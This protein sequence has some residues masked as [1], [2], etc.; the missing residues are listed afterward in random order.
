M[1]KSIQAIRGMNDLLPD[2][3]A[4]WQ[5]V[6]QTARDTLHAYGYREIRF[7][8]VEKTDLFCRAVGQATDIVE[9]E[10][11]TFDDRNGDSL[12]LRPEGTACAVRTG[13]E[14][15]LLHNQVQRLWYI[16]PMFRHERP[17]KGRY[18]QFHQIGVE[19]FGMSGPDIDAE[20][21]MLS[22]R[23][24]RA[25]GLEG[26]TLELNS[27]GTPDARKQYR[28]ELVKYL[29]KHRDSLDNDSLRRLEKNPLRVLDSKDPG[30]QKIVANAPE[31]ADYLDEESKT[32]FARLKRYL[33][34]AG[35]AYVVNPRLVRGLDYYSRTVFEWTTDQLGAQSAVCAGGRFD[36]LVE[37][38]GGKATA[39]TGFAM[40][41]ER[42]VELLKLGDAPRADVEPQV[43]I[44][45]L[46]EQAE[47]I[48]M[49]LGESLRAEGLRILCHCGSGGMKGQMKKADKSGAAVALILGDDECNEGVVAVKHLR[50]KSDQE[51]VPMNTLAKRLKKILSAG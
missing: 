6:E 45:M 1:S 17:Q 13:I 11:Y 14:H 36:G 26:L 3:S 28:E 16:G 40:G 41:I 29:E 22:A 34:D 50:I 5:F 37:Q 44:V 39:A 4:I 27:L 7:P 24:F 23:F 2:E 9:K 31:L 8:I 51:M 20:I 38:M 46:G 48:G 30:T 32:H 18:R 10:M 19:T 15:G 33:S 47:H 49:Q 35:I 12:S 25:L 42:L 43:Y 21:I